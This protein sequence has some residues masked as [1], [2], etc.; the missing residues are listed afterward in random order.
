MLEKEALQL[1]YCRSEYETNDAN[2]AEGKRI[3]R[4]LGYLAL[5][6]DQAGAYI[7][8]RTIKFQ[9]YI[10]H[11][12]NRREEVLKETPDL[13]DYRRKK[14]E[15]EAEQ[16]LS[17]A[18]TWELSF[19]QIVGDVET[20]K[21]KQH[22][23][24]LA[25]FFHN[26]SISEELFVTYR[27]SE[28]P[29]WMTIFV[30]EGVWDKYKFL[31][32]VA[33]LRNLSLIQSL[34]SGAAA[35]SFSLHPLIQD[36]TKLRLSPEARQKYAT[37]AMLILSEYINAQDAH[38]RTLQEKQTIL[39]HLN[40]ALENDKACLVQG[41]RLG[42]L[43]LRN[44]AISFAEFFQ[45]QGRYAEA[46]T[47]YNQV[48]TECEK[49]LG[50]EHPDTLRTV[51]NLA[52][53][54][55]NQGR[56]GEAETLYKQVLTGQETQLG[57]KHPDTLRTVG[58]LAIIYRNQGRYGEAET[59]YNQVLTEC[60]KQLGPEHPDI[61]QAVVNLAIV[62]R[63]Q[64]RYEE[65]ET[66]YKRALTEQE[67]QLSPEHPETLRTVGNLA[68]VCRNQGRYEEAETLYKQALTGQET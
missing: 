13:W 56:Y 44:P 17:V 65:A 35:T 11:Y 39:S 66:L 1:L 58:N 53:V 23:L 27:K 33:E 68:I 36:W 38:R 50:P 43:F 41:T 34:D 9:S 16:S 47:L 67:T 52:I 54:Y 37:E 55:R 2:D 14:N 64:R 21:S 24:T 31:D 40:T 60:E 28:T 51:G 20:Q 46:E 62:Y 63:N 5:A 4:R 48:L 3:I 26:D 18:T 22:L 61:L 29:P 30:S 10:D 8:A 59:L 42:E 12:N 6:I 57:P 25:A 32:V 15:T 7:L 49:Q 45:D 19:E